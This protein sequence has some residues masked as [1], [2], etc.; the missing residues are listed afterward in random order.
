MP[1]LTALSVP[2]DDEIV[3]AEQLFATGS[4]PRASALPGFEG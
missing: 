3:A 4:L 1:A 2:A